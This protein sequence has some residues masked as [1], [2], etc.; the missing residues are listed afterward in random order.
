MDLIKRINFLIVSPLPTHS[1]TSHSILSSVYRVLRIFARIL[2]DNVES[3]ITK[4]AAKELR[5]KLSA[6]GEQQDHDYDEILKRIIVSV[7]HPSDDDSD[8]AEEVVYEKKYFDYLP[9]D[10]DSEDVTD[11]DATHELVKSV[12]DVMSSEHERPADNGRRVN[13][14]KFKRDL[15]RPKRQSIFYVPVPLVRYS[16][17]PNADFY[18]PQDFHRFQPYPAASSVQNRFSDVRPNHP[19]PWSPQYNPGKFH[20]PNNFYLPALMPSKPNK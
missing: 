14:R 3:Y 4:E 6:R 11:E 15:S 5:N 1:P 8:N 9:N 2:L 12:G 13:S 7:Q 19:N 10:L 18:Y 16:P 17:Y 20:A